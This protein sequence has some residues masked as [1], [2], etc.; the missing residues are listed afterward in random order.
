MRRTALLALVV[1]FVA[2]TGPVGAVPPAAGGAL[3]SDNVDFIARIP[4]PGA[5]GGRIIGN[6]MYVT[7]TQGLRIFDITAPEVPVLL[8]ALPIAHFGNEDVDTNGRIALIGTDH[9]L[10][11]ANTLYVID[12]TN[13]RLPTLRSRFQPSGRAH[14][15]SCIADCTYAWVAGS[16]SVSVVDLRDPS[17]PR[18]AGRFFINGSSQSTGGSFGTSHDVNVD[19][20]GTAWISSSAGLFGYDPTNPVNPTLIAARRNGTPTSFVNNFIVHNSMRPNAASTDQTKLGDANV[21]EGELVLVTEENWVTAQNG[22]CRDDGSFQTGWMH[23][24]NGV[25]TVDRLDSVKLGQGGP[26]PSQKPQPVATCSSH[27]FD[28]R[29]GI[30]AVAWYEQGVRFFDVSDPRA[31]RQVGFFLGADATASAALF[32]GN[33]VYVFDLVR[34]IDVIR[35]SGSTASPTIDGPR[36]V[37][38][39]PIALEPDL[40]FGFACRVA[41]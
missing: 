13:P 7:G 30:A 5:F 19:A 36:L 16:N 10:S 22:F 40:A 6:T 35:F 41:A 34:G 2:A 1:A 23:T 37:R 4:E 25:L 24:V 9:A 21:D 27:W 31:I 12:V 28:Y 26:L 14:T 17:A 38:E 11:T 29:E 8:G 20:Q 33:V 39:A 3:A 15:A 18:Q 32:R